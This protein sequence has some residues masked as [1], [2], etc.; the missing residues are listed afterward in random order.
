MFEIVCKYQAV[1][2]VVLMYKYRRPTSSQSQSLF[3]WV[4]E[5]KSEIYFHWKRRIDSKKSS[6]YIFQV[7][8]SLESLIQLSSS[9]LL[10]FQFSCLLV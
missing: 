8:V 5:S 6:F 7:S 9:F 2:Y 3:G 4:I 1:C 10:L